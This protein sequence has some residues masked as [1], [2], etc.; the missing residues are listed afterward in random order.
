[1]GT[2][3]SIEQENAWRAGALVYSGR[4]DPVWIVPE[5]IVESLLQLWEELDDWSGT[6][7]APPALGYKGCYVQDAGLRKW[8]A[9]NGFVSL[10]HDRETLIKK[11]MARAFEKRILISAPAGTLPPWLAQQEF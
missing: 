2:S 5:D 8:T 9:F 4:P 1:M 10:T 7:P 11:D 3:R 6:L